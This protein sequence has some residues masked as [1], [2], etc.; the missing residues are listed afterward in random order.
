[1][2]RLKTENIEARPA[3][4]KLAKPVPPALSPKPQPKKKVSPAAVAAKVALTNAPAPLAR[5]A[6]KRAEQSIGKIF[7]A[8]EQVILRTGAERISILDVCKSAGVSRG[9]F[10]RYFASQEALLDDFARHK[11]E[12]FH[13]ELAET[14]SPYTDPDERFAAMCNFLDTYLGTNRSRRLLLV[15][16]E[17]ALMHFGRIFHDSL[18]RFQILLDPVFDAWD[19]R[20]QMTLDRELVC[21]LMVRFMLSE[22]LVGDGTQRAAMPR[23]I[24]RMV[25]ALR[26]GGPTLV[27]R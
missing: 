19:T 14:L 16:P 4:R 10:Y 7:S 17:F 5:R 21:E 23:R 26:F 18:V 8:T 11:R 22:H 3:S 1:M 6:N 12:S 15:A 20:L 25:R 27:R 9:T 13:I 2:S 24:G